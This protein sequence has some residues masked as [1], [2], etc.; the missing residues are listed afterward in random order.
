[1][2]DHPLSSDGVGE[3]SSVTQN[4]QSHEHMMRYK[5]PMTLPTRNTVR[6][7]WTFPTTAP[8][9]LYLISHFSTDTFRFYNY[10][11]PMPSTKRKST[12]ST[13]NS[14]PKKRRA[15]SPS[16]SD[17][18]DQE[19]GTASSD[20]YQGVNR[21][22]G[23]RK[24]EY[25]SEDLDEDS[26]SAPQPTRKTKT[27]TRVASSPKKAK[28]KTPRER[29]L[30]KGD[31]DEEYDDEAELKEGQEIVGRVVKA[32]TTGR[33]ASSPLSYY[34]FHAKSESS[35]VPPGRISQNTLDFLEK[36]KDPKCNDREWCV[37][38]SLDS[39]SAHS[40]P[41]ASQVPPAR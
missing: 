37:R 4:H 31:E 36:L 35:P 30:P 22:S 34:R 13:P 18:E 16:E 20:N 29:K 40:S 38:S 17:F 39:R 21:A 24:R 3:G 28:A 23:E 7:N 14:A 19:E 32:P 10:L 11:T 12:N 8:S 26:D 2:G 33:G 9:S 25:D 1:V 5:T 41:A 27:K 6:G 15:A